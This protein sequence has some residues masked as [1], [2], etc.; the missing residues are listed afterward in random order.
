MHDNTQA[1]ALTLE[2]QFNL[3]AFEH[4]IQDIN[5]EQAQDL[6]IHLYKQMLMQENCYKSL[7]KQQWGFND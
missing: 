4:Q 6:L 1:I 3:K 7:I 2:Q 5:R